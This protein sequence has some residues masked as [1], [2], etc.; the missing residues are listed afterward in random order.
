MPLLERHLGWLQGSRDL[1]HLAPPRPQGE[2]LILVDHPG[3]ALARLLLSMP[4]PPLGDPSLPAF[5]L[6]AEILC[7]AYTSRMNQRLRLS[8]GWTYGVSC[9]VEARPEAGRLV[10]ELPLAPE[11]LAPALVAM[12]EILDQAA[13]DLPTEAEA[14]AA[15]NGLRVQAS[16]DLLS[17][18]RLAWRLGNR[19]TREE[20]ADAEAR[21]VAAAATLHR[22]SAGAGPAA[23]GDRGDRLWLV[24]GDARAIEP[25]LAEAGRPASLLWTGRSVVGRR[26]PP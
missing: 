15:R 11:H 1:P 18:A 23:L 22:C 21:A 20:P 17:D 8:E 10:V 19:L 9:R 12:E 16:Q 24:V 2:R 14:R 3:V 6:D 5:E 26:G 13:L 25:L 7:G 4:A